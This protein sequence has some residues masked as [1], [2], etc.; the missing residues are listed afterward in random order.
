M[1]LALRG[2]LGVVGVGLLV[3]LLSALGLETCDQTEPFQ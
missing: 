1:K 3:L 2:A